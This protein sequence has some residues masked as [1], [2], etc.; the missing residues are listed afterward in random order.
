MLQGRR[1]G[2]SKPWCESVR[3]Y[4][5]LPVKLNTGD[6]IFT[7][8]VFGCVLLWQ[9]YEEESIMSLTLGVTDK[10][11]IYAGSYLLLDFVRSFVR[12]R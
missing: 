5:W 8:F 6:R 3:V 12:T 1:T 11:W 7:L 10:Y 9:R 2:S 4:N